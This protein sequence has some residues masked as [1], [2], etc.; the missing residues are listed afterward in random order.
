MTRDNEEDL[1]RGEFEAL[2]AE[3][4]RPGAVPDFGDM[5]ARARR[6]AGRMDDAPVVRTLQHRRVV[7]IGGWMS[8][9][10]AAAAVGLLLVDTGSLDRD[11]EFE[12]MVASYSASN[13]TTWRSPTSALLDLPGLDLGSVPSIGRGVRGVNRPNQDLPDGRDS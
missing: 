13:A 9:A 3:S 1:I 7:R 11:A 5:M 6:D 12:R 8:L 2:R 4:T 10:A